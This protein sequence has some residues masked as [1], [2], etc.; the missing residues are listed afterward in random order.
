MATD[1]Q[2]MANRINARHSTGP[3]TAE[4]KANA[5]AAMP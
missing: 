4:G 2:I 1:A 3:K 5:P